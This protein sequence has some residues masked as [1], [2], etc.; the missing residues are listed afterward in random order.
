MDISLG[1]YKT[2]MIDAL[3]WKHSTP[4]GTKFKF[5]SDTRKICLASCAMLLNERYGLEMMALILQ[6]RRMHCHCLSAV[7]L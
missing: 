5:I 2:G 4:V 3:Y 6:A 1:N 7:I